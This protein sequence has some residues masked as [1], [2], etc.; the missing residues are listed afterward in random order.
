M[1]DLISG[2]NNSIQVEHK[3]DKVQAA[4]YLSFCLSGK[5]YGIG[6]LEV[7]EIIE[8][9][10]ITPLPLAPDYIHGV[11]N[12]R[13]NA[14]PVIN[15][16]IRLGYAATDIDKRSCIVLVEISNT[17]GQAQT[18]GI[19]VDSVREIL[20]I[21]QDSILPAPQMG[22]SV[23]TRFIQAM[24]RLDDQFIIL[25]DINKLLSSEQLQ[26]LDDLAQNTAGDTAQ[27]NSK[28]ES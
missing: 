27:V 3:S 5:L 22:E 13:G 14:V 11:I 16:T 10:A 4:Q 9:G 7:E 12:L 17:Q 15:L 28:A 6:I 23:D 8:T 19:L 2:F 25:L 24:G 26:G 18:I 20:E 21:E 1:A